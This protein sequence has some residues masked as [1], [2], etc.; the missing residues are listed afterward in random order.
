MFRRVLDI[1]PLQL[2]TRI[3]SGDLPNLIDVREEW[4]WNFARIEN[5]RRIPLGEFAQTSAT[6]SHDDDIVVYCHHGVR[7]LM[8]AQFLVNHGFK[9]V[10]NLVG[11][12]DRYS[13]EVD[14]TIPRY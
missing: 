10:S 6:L 12:I 7:S 11:G 5:A 4:E 13:V 3:K 1:E 8:A 9:S 2:A 14:P